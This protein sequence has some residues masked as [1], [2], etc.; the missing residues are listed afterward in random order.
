MRQAVEAGVAYVSAAGNDAE[1]HLS[2]IF[3]FTLCGDFHDFGGTTCT[4]HV[5]VEP[6]DTLECVLQWND[7]FPGAVDDYDLFVVDES[8]AVLAAGEELQD[9]TQEPIEFVSWSNTAPMPR[10]VGLRIRKTRGEPR[11]LKMFCFGGEMQHVTPRG[12]IFGHP[13]LAEVLAAGAIDVHEGGLAAVEPYSS[14]GP[15]ELFFPV[16][17]RAKPDVTAFDAVTT[18]VA[19]FTPFFG[20]SAAAAHVAGGAPRVLAKNPFLTPGDVSALVRG[21]ALDVSP[22]GPD[23][24]SGAGRLDAL[25]AVAAV[26]A[27]ECRATA[28][29]GGACPIDDCNGG[30]CTHSAVRGVAIEVCAGQP[31]PAGIGRRFERACRLV[32]RIPTA[33]TPRRANRLT[34]KTLAALGRAARIAA[35]AGRS[36]VSPACGAAIGAALAEAERLVVPP[37]AQRR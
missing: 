19:G 12:S 35:R 27:P 14:Q 21:A 22:P 28:E 6:F 5:V 13:A 9:G 11:L 20:T 8:L 31:V 23:S 33:P 16:A 26:K 1:R 30:T 34:R 25:G 15:A 24:A 36:Q 32:A 18:A 17:T 7:P 10:T 4:S 2:Q 3:R 37:A 29:C